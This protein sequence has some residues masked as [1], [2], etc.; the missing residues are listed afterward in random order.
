ML[1]G[2]GAGTTGIPEA[3]TTLD[4]VLRTTAWC[5]VREQREEYLVY[6]SRT[7]ELHLISP[8][9]HYLYLLCDGLRTVGEVQALFEPATASAIPGFLA[10]LVARGV[11][12]PVAACHDQRGAP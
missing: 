11:L 10:T 6:N 7:D 1:T 2:T 12:Q 8:L 9:G 4:T 3:T 5:V